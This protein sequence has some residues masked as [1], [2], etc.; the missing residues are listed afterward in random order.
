MPDGEPAEPGEQSLIIDQ[1]GI[2]VEIEECILGSIRAVKGAR[3]TLRNCILDATDSA[4]IAFAGKAPKSSRTK[5]PLPMIDIG[6]TKHPVSAGAALTLENCTVFGK[7]QTERLELASNTLFFSDTDNLTDGALPPLFSEQRQSGCVRF[8]YLPVGSPPV[9]NAYRCQPA[10]AMEVALEL[11]RREVPTASE[12]HL[13]EIAKAV[14][15]RVVP[16]F[17]SRRYGQPGYGLLRPDTDPAL[18]AG[19]DNNSE[20]GVFNQLFHARRLT[21][22]QG[23]F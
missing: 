9:P 18:L 22:L 21:N 10:T 15:V 4:G 6:A 14:R 16:V 2:S 1:P 17:V 20:I 11:A 7:V 8:C 5:S 19:A 13:S 3:V 23:A 12:A